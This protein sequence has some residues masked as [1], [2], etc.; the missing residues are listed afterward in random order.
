MK[1]TDGLKKIILYFLLA[2][3]LLAVTASIDGILKGENEG[4]YRENWLYYELISIKLPNNI[5][6]K[7]LSSERY[8]LGDCVLYCD[9]LVDEEKYA[10]QY[11]KDRITEQN[12]SLVSS[13]GNKS[14]YVKKTIVLTVFREDSLYK[15]IFTDCRNDKIAYLYNLPKAD[16]L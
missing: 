5:V 1:C 13:D 8:L 15:F 11:I 3:L 12:W 7:E 14:S 10:E 16:V 9:F 6:V 2:L 4:R